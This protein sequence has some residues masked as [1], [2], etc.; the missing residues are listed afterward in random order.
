M[1]HQTI[2]KQYDLSDQV[3]IVTG[4]A[5]ILCAEICRTLSAAGAK[6]AVLD[7]DLDSG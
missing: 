2:S 3:A 6:V 4:G 5:G 1:D 7:L